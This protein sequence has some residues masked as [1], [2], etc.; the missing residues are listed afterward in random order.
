[1]TTDDTAAAVARLDA[2]LA[3]TAATG[4]LQALRRHAVGA[5]RSALA[6]AAG[7]P[8]D[9]RWRFLARAVATFASRVPA[10]SAQSGYTAAALARLNALVAENL[11]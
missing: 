4:E 7:R 1:M 2:D 8:D 6:F 3:A 11:R 9:P 10:G 5:Y